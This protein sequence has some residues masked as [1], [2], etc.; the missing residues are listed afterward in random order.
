MRFD[1]DSFEAIALILGGAY[2]VLYR[3]KG[4]LEAFRFWRSHPTAD[5]QGYERLYLVFGILLI[6]SGVYKAFRLFGL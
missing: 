2:T 4:A 5:L 6:V 3:R 1:Y